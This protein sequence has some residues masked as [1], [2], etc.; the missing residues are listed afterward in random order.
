MEAIAE[1]IVADLEPAD[2]WWSSDTKG[3]LERTASAM[4]ED[5]D[6]DSVAE[7]MSEIIGAVRNE[8]GD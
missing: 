1:R 2:G 7:A 8:Y 6:E 5:M 4:L 3:T